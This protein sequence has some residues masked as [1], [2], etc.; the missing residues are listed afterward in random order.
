MED[1]LHAQ[2]L[3]APGG[4][5]SER[6]N[7]RSTRVKRRTTRSH[8]SVS[9][10]FGP[11]AVLLLG[12]GITVFG[13]VCPSTR[14]EKYIPGCQIIFVP[15]GL[16]LPV[17][18]LVVVIYLSM[19]SKQKY[20]SDSFYS[21]ALLEEI[22]SSSSV[23]GVYQVEGL[24]NKNDGVVVFLV[25]VGSV[26]EIYTYQVD[27]VTMGGFCAMVVQLPGSGVLKGVR[28]SLPRAEKVVLSALRREGLWSDTGFGE[29]ESLARIVDLCG[30]DAQYFVEDEISSHRGY[31]IVLAS[32][33]LSS[34]VVMHLASSQRLGN[35][36]LSGV[37]LY[38]STYAP[39]R[40]NFLKKLEFA[41]Y[42]IYWISLLVKWRQYAFLHREVR[43]RVALDALNPEARA[44]WA[45][46]F[47]DWYNVLRS[48]CSN[49]EGPVLCLSRSRTSLETMER[50]WSKAASQNLV[51]SVHLGRL[52][53][54][55]SSYFFTRQHDLHDSHLLSFV[56]EHCLKVGFQSNAQL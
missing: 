51:R 21:D 56:S 20:A 47:D 3:D 25:G 37:V 34:H 7:A 18:V 5:L 43:E 54:G 24:E 15:L 17:V 46:D 8:V 10:A 53:R 30:D 42:R 29:Q 12:L 22:L 35:K 38:C 11:L 6:H 52:R 28:F 49:Y 40:L 48:A 44:D 26:P 41:S 23:E 4:A 36:G 31:K 9:Q 27:A 33:G 14:V 39:Q 55:G 2:L 32:W 19:P 13:V 16:L 1:P 45:V 50:V